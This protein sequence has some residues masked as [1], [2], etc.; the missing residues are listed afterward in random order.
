MESERSLH[1]LSVL[2]AIG[3]TAKQF[4]LPALVAIFAARSRD[5]WEA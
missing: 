5:A 1:P 4:L 3:D 2:F